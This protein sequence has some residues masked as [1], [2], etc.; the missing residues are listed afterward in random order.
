MKKTLILVLAL[1]VAGSAWAQES[2]DRRLA[3]SKA[4]LV[5]IDNVAGSVTVAGWDSDEVWVTG[6]LGKGTER[7]EFSSAGDRTVIRVVLPQHS[8]N[9]DGSFLE[10]RLPKQSR[11]DIETVSADIEV[12]GVFGREDVQ[13]VSGSIAVRGVPSELVAETVSGE[14][15]VDVGTD[16]VRLES[17][18]GDIEVKR[19]TRELEAETVSGTISARGE[20]PASLDLETVSGRIRYEGGLAKG[21]RCAASTV[22]GE[23]ELL[24]PKDIDA[25]FEISTFSGTI[26]SDFGKTVERAVGHHHDH[27]HGHDL[28]FVSGAGSARVIVKSFSGTV[29]IRGL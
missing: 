28:S 10:V 26:Q 7:L 19:V 21:A 29:R 3:A 13:S 1:V 16:R 20:S 5:E 27:E 15:G 6:T 11:L 4:G 12:E 9:V 18:S 23:V 8:R 14:L 2:V 25:G 24:L 17:V 22:S